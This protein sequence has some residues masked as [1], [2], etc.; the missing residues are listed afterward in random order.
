L[1]ATLAAV[2][3]GVS[4]VAQPPT[5]R[6]A[7]SKAAA[8]FIDEPFLRNEGRNCQTNEAS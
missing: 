3:A 7:S 8:G 5:V 1:G 4:V 2:S 6:S